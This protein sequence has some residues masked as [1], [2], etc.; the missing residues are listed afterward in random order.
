MAVKKSK[1]GPGRPPKNR[2][3]R[4]ENAGVP[5]THKNPWTGELVKKKRVNTACTPWGW[6]YFKHVLG[7]FSALDRKA[8]EYYKKR[9]ENEKPCPEAEEAGLTRRRRRADAPQ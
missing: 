4:H 9:I 7:G 1:R 3:R 5:R 6:L 2:D 8:A